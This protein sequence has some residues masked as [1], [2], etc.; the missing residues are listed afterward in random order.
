MVVRRNDMID[1]IIKKLFKKNQVKDV[2][3]TKR[4]KVENQ[5][6]KLNK[7]NLI[8]KKQVC[9]FSEREKYYQRLFSA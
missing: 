5:Q 8:S 1:F 4:S 9:N 3:I 6:A 7:F 2:K